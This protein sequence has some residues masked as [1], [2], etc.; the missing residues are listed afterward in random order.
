MG[1]HTGSDGA[2]KEPAEATS[3]AILPRCGRRQGWAMHIWCF[4]III[5]ELELEIPRLLDSPRRSAV[6][7]LASE[8]PMRS[9]ALKRAA[10]GMALALGVGV[11]ALAADA[12]AA[13]KVPLPKPRPIARSA[14][15]KTV[16][17][18]P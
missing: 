14:V 13:A 7:R 4:G 3:A 18:S 11:S 12:L 8:S 6:T 1:S 16:V 17:A 15:P 5:N 2:A 10:L 9:K